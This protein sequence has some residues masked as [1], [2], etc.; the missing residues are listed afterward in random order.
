MSLNFDDSSYNISS[1]INNYVESQNNLKTEIQ[2]ETDN[3]IKQTD[4]YTIEPS[5]EDKLNKDYIA[6]RQVIYYFDIIKSHRIQLQSQITDYWLENST[7]VQD[8]INHAPII[9]TLS[10]LVGEIVYTPPTKFVDSIV[11]KLNAKFPQNNGFTFTEKL[12]TIAGIIPTVDNYTQLAKNAINYTETAYNRYKSI[13]DSIMDWRNGVKNNAVPRQ[14]KV[15]KNLER[16]WSNNV[17]LTVKTPFGTF[18]SMYIQNLSMEQGETNTVS[19]ITV[20]LK[21][22]SFKEVKYTKAD[23]K[24][25]SD[26][27]AQAQ[28]QTENLGE[29]TS[30]LIALKRMFG[31]K[32]YGKGYKV[33]PYPKG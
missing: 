23:K 18:E 3:Y 16:F 28:A 1:S 32:N 22:L 9:I 2:R 17:P 13:Y 27:N 6:E 14:E 33:M 10:G 24:V 21:Q 4:L 25:L 19:D 8:S 12:G 29:N 11:D 26:L 30:I 5:A 15:Y 31:D 20:T 7:A